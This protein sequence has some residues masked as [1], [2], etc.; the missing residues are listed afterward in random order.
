MRLSQVVVKILNLEHCKIV[1]HR[2]FANI[3]ST[4]GLKISPAASFR[5]HLYYQLIPSREAK[6]ERE[7]AIIN[8]NLE[9]E[10]VGEDCLIQVLLAL[11]RLPKATGGNLTADAASMAGAA[12]TATLAA[13]VQLPMQ[14]GI[15]DIYN[16]F[17]T[18]GFTWYQAGRAPYN[19]SI[20]S[21]DF[22][23]YLTSWLRAVHKLHITYWMPPLQLAEAGDLGPSQ[24]HAQPLATPLL[25]LLAVMCSEK[26]TATNGPRCKLTV[27]DVLL[28]ET[29]VICA[30]PQLP[31]EIGDLINELEKLVI[32]LPS[33]L[34]G[35]AVHNIRAAATLL[36][37]ASFAK[38]ATSVIR[39]DALVFC[40][41]GRAQPTPDA[42]TCNCWDCKMWSLIVQG[43]FKKKDAGSRTGTSR[44]QARLLLRLVECSLMEMSGTTG[45]LSEWLTS[46]DCTLEHI[47]PEGW[48]LAEWQQDWGS[49]DGLASMAMHRLGNL[50]LLPKAVNSS[51]RDLHWL[52]DHN[53]VRG[54]GKKFKIQEFN[55]SPRASTKLNELLVQVTEISCYSTYFIHSIRCFVLSK[56]F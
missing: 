14:H 22:T 7:H 42:S 55:N 37:F 51:L 2:M 33:H 50:T 38:T 31:T 47:M 43:E 40:I 12:L 24:P 17:F 48:V 53:N 49:K 15:R 25:R 46:E 35:E 28:I 29:I 13:E 45:K 10:K 8:F 34:T 30:A 18:D 32:N 52:T 27:P 54:S 9:V 44:Q 23:N 6:P 1:Q 4:L 36:S 3:N 21:L 16:F 19:S 39:R 5:A 11:M 41:K 26:S 20:H 56:R